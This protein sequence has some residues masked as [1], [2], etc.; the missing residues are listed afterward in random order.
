MKISVII[1]TCNRF[2]DLR[3]ALQSF[4]EMFVPPGLSWELII[5]DN[6]SNDNTKDVFNEFHRKNILPLMYIFVGRQGKSFAL[7]V[8][9]KDAKGEILAF[10]D[11][12]AI[13]DAYW[14]TSILKEFTCD[15]SIAGLG[16]RVELFN[17]KDASVTI[18]TN[19]ERILLSSPGQLLNP[20]IIGCNMAFK[21][22]VFDEV[23]EIDPGL[24]PGCKIESCEDADFVYRVYKKGFKMI[25]SPDVLVYHNHGR[26]T[27]KEVQSLNQKYVI[28]RGSLYCK[29]ILR[30]DIN[31]LLM[32]CWEMYGILTSLIKNLLEGK[33]IE[34]NRRRLCNLMTGVIYQATS[35]KVK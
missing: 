12:D 15:T 2:E 4:E 5:V 31:I 13:V 34:K 1:A 20:P 24:G 8:G 19:K 14:L 10:T 21:K 7:N 3:R 25:Y 27:E 18:R 30:G 26:R 22:N 9:I 16:G 29:Y 17:K 28:G 11:D 33:P 35:F 32:A 6:N 23:R